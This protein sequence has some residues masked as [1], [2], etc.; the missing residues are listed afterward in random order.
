MDREWNLRVDMQVRALV[1]SARNAAGLRI[2]R[3]A[4]VVIVILPRRPRV[5]WFGRRR[6]RSLV[7]CRRHRHGSVFAR[8]DGA[9]VA[10]AAIDAVTVS[11][12]VFP[13]SLPD[14]L[15]A[16]LP[17]HHSTA[18]LVRSPLRYLMSPSGARARSK[19]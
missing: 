2:F 11:L 5:R 7:R 16:S 18:W 14:H 4:S 17:Q 19:L 3:L 13:P 9:S 6:H 8:I 10:C 12:P 1:A 15:L